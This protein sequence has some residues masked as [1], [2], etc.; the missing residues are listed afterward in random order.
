MRLFPEKIWKKWRNWTNKNKWDTAWMYCRPP[1]PLE[2][3]VQF[4]FAKTR[5]A[6]A[7]STRKLWLTYLFHKV[8]KDFK[9]WRKNCWV[10][11]Q[12]VRDA[13][14]WGDFGIFCFLKEGSVAAAGSPRL[15]NYVVEKTVS[16]VKRCR[17]VSWCLS[18]WCQVNLKM[19]SGSLEHGALVSEL[20]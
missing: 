14:G 12:G 15:V 13:A 7:R 18:F 9:Y 16:G 10:C 11:R 2:T 20:N 8:S 19:Q 6:T 1:S 17:V 4:A 5:V 3:L